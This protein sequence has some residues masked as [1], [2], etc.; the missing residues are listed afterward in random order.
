MS[1]SSS[2]LTFGILAAGTIFPDWQAE[3]LKKLRD[4]ECTHLELLIVDDGEPT[5]TETETI[6]NSSLPGV[7]E[8]SREGVYRTFWD[9]YR[10][11]IDHPS[12]ISSV[13]LTKELASIDHIRCQLEGSATS[14]SLTEEDIR[15]IEDYDLDFVL[16]FIPGSL[17]G[18]I[19]HIPQYGVWSFCH[20][21]E[22]DDRSDVPGFW[23]IYEG[24]TVTKASLNQI[25]GQDQR[26]RVLREGYF[27]TNQFSYARN[28]DHV[29][30]GT[31]EW[32][33][34]AAID[35][36]NKNDEYTDTSPVKTEIHNRST[37][38][39]LHILSYNLKRT[40]SLGTELFSGIDCW[41]VGVLE[42]SIEECVNGPV[43]PEINW[44]PQ[45]REDGY[46]ADPFPITID[47]TTYIFVEDFSYP[48][49][50]GKISYLEYPNGFER[51]ALQTAH[52]EPFHMSYPYIFKHE[53]D[54]YATPEVH[55]SEEIRLY[56]VIR[57]SE[58]EI[59]ATLA[60]DVA[61]IDPTV[62]EHKGRW[63][64]FHTEKAYDNTKLYL[65]YAETLTGDWRPHRNNPVKTDIRT[66]RP[67]GTPFVKD[68]QLYRPAQYSAGDYGKR[69][70]INRVTELSPSQYAEEA[71]A[72]LQP[73]T[74]YPYR[75]GMHTLSSR[76]T[77]TL[78]D[79]KQKVRNKYA[80]KQGMRELSA[81]F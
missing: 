26:D 67:G 13:D 61:C 72:E 17:E 1:E 73:T 50:K 25:M 8:T 23:E 36:V 44:C 39:P 78:V 19:L 14:R 24:L 62:F 15:T 27:S 59:K 18:E 60:R 46:I 57:P 37:P 63:W 20:G 77:I 56:Q 11:S 69:I 10:S 79:G 9:W 49:W 54:V 5:Y 7:G 32:P 30:Y 53:G 75:D 45:P 3:C 48:D 66:A 71:V 43:D 52:E 47:G 31:T 74:R 41:N 29:F 16:L 58:W 2:E 70:V 4:L 21:G 12:C 68:E 42:T 6:P 34:Q 33:T 28:L 80:L 65:R 55:E 76:G 64:M 22:Q 51:G 81:A 40:Y 38:S 35:I